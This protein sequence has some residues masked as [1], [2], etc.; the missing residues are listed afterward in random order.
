MF[1]KPRNQTLNRQWFEILMHAWFV[2]DTLGQDKDP[3][4]G[5]DNI[6]WAN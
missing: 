1:R 4:L 2:S 3:M 6:V 5:L